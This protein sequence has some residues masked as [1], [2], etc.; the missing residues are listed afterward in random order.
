MSLLNQVLQDLEKR[1]PDNTAEHQSFDHL[2]APT[3]APKYKPSYLIL[4]LI[5]I[6]LIASVISLNIKQNKEPI[7][8]AIPEKVQIAA[9]T[10]K[11]KSMPA[12]A[13]IT[14]DKN[15]PLKP[16]DLPEKQVLKSLQTEEAEI[17]ITKATNKQD[18]T[19]KTVEPSVA[20]STL[21]KKQQEFTATAI[22]TVKNT[23]LKPIDQTAEKTE[24]NKT[25]IIHKKDAFSAVANKTTKTVN[26][27]I[28]KKPILQKQKPLNLNQLAEQAFISAQKPQDLATRQ[29][30]LQQVLKL[31]INHIDARLLL[32]NTLLQQGLT[33]QSSHLL[34]Q[35][36][37][38]FPQNLD[39]IKLRSQT[40]LQSKQPVAAIQL[41]L[42]TKPST[43]QDENY[44]ALLAAA[45]QQNNQHIKSLT[46]YQ[47]LLAL[48]PEKAEY[49][50]GLA[51]A[52]ENQGNKH[53]ALIA[54][55]QAVNKKTLQNAVV[56]YINQ[57]ISI[58][59]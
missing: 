21:I 48:N 16:I 55:Q 8:K 52:Q 25:K 45:Y 2:S 19:K 46:L 36:L 39:F 42:K 24:V 56:S 37:K 32:A 34:D 29:L 58:L 23:Q 35:G 57:R 4:T 9:A 40:F 44:L 41:L 28:V 27:T 10:N 7:I 50:L 18:D 47:E 11:Q 43:L 17:N 33:K 31:N 53:Q 6:G 38:L 3:P 54:Y 1:K 59:R 26:P 30:K 5:F 22:A 12:T 15:T 20:K 51:I 49:W 14:E 13:V